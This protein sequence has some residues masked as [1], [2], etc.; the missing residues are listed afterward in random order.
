MK[1]YMYILKIMTIRMRLIEKKLELKS[2]EF[3]FPMKLLKHIIKKITRIYSS[4]NACPR[5]IK[6][7]KRQ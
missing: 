1:L 7:K 6:V 4:M 5:L 3:V 2:S